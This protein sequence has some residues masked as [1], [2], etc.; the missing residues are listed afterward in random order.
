MTAT[1]ILAALSRDD[2][3]ITS[4]RRGELR[5]LMDECSSS[6]RTASSD[7][8][9]RGILDAA[10]RAAGGAEASQGDFVPGPELAAL[11]AV[12]VL[13]AGQLRGTLE[14]AIVATVCAI[15]TRHAAPAHVR[16]EALASGIIASRLLA[17][18]IGEQLRARGW[19]VTAVCSTVGAAVAG[20]R[21]LGLDQPETVHAV[22][23]AATQATGLARF[24][25]G[26]LGAFQRGKAAANAVVAVEAAANGLTGPTSALEGRR[27]L[28]AVMLGGEDVR[29]DEAALADAVTAWAD[30]PAP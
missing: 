15:G 5:R 6:L 8:R 25:S 22:A 14:Q 30:A 3:Q 16:E 4:V 10:R 20:A 1:E 29:L 2:L 11:V 27:G 17:G 24:E 28:F 7:D 19:S 21:L 13:E 18:T 26:S 23:L 12:A 9:A